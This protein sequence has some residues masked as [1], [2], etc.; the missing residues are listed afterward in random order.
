MGEYRRGF[1]RRKGG[2]VGFI[3]SGEL[4][5]TPRASRAPIK[6]PARTSWAGLLSRARAVILFQAL[7]KEQGRAAPARHQ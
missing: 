1:L 3:A 7:S 4:G 5:G 2:F 6:S